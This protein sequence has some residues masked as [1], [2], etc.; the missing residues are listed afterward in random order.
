MTKTNQQKI[1]TANALAQMTPEAELTPAEAAEYLMS[2]EARLL[3]MRADRIGSRFRKD[4]TKSP[5]IT[6][7]KRDLDAWM[8][9]VKTGS[10][11]PTPV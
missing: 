5:P 6:Y 11:R 1:A 4:D 3:K 2:S 10:S 9:S 7:V 8:D